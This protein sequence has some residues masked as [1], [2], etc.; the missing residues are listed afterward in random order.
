MT[1]NIDEYAELAQGLIDTY[2]ERNLLFQNIEGARLF[3][4]ATITS[5][6]VFIPSTTF[7]LVTVHERVL[8]AAWRPIF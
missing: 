4:K 7:G 5:G 2:S 6:V 3:N 1:D 8:I